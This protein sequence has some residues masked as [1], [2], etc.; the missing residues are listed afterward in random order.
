[1]ANARKGLVGRAAWRVVAVAGV[2]VGRA[3]FTDPARIVQIQFGEAPELL[4]GAEILADGAVVDTLRRILRRT[5]MGFEIP[6][7]AR[8]LSLH[9]PASAHTASGR[10]SAHT[11]SPAALGRGKTLRSGR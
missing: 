9:V 7:G 5:L 1:M 2:L 10:G 6:A 8:L 3:C 4:E 11:G